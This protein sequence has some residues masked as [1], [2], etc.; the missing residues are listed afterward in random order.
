MK[1]D[2][3]YKSIIYHLV[4]LTIQFGIPVPT[5]NSIVFYVASISFFGFQNLMDNFNKAMGNVVNTI[6][7]EVKKSH[8]PQHQHQ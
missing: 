5:L 4:S 7:S 2:I 6:L 1:S 3:N 8:H